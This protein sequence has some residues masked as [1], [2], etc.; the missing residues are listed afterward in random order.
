M[1]ALDQ[2]VLDR[3]YDEI[4]RGMP[5]D[6]IDNQEIVLYGINGDLSVEEARYLSRRLDRKGFR[7]SLITGDYATAKREA[8]SDKSAYPIDLPFLLNEV[9]QG[10]W[11]FNIFIINCI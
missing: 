7:T 9:L 4:I 3:I 11:I 8:F 2:K 5:V 10:K 6:G 1:A